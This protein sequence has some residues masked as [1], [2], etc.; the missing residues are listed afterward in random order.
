[1]DCLAFLVDLFFPKVL[2]KSQLFAL[3][4]LTGVALGLTPDIRGLLGA[5]LFFITYLSTYFYNDLLDLEY[6]LK[7]PVYPAKLLVRGKMRASEALFLSANLFALGVFLT[8]IYDA[9][10]GLIAFLA[11][12]INNLRSHV[13]D[14]LTRQG[15]LV[16]VEFL[17]F[18]AAYYAF[19]HAI[20][21]LLASS[22]AIEFASLYA[23]GH[24]VYKFRD[25]RLWQVLTHKKSILLTVLA[26]LFMPPTVFALSRNSVALVFGVLSGF[27][28]IL[29]QYFLVRHG[30]LAEQAFVDMSFWSDAVLM[31]LIA[32]WYVLG[33]WLML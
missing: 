33:I 20:P 24:N 2:K 23:L 17:N 10:L 27:I 11:V 29:P 16:L 9:V 13:R 21:D 19:F 12:L 25:G 26:F 8:T 3:A 15:L 6:D 7:K 14:V 5:T 22:V 31:G 18:S 32:L 4:V 1:M 30:D 28:Y